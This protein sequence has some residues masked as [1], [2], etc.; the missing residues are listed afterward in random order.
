MNSEPTSPAETPKVETPV[1]PEGAVLAIDSS[2]ADALPTIEAPEP[3]QTPGAHM[4]PQKLMKMLKKMVDSEQLTP[5]QART[6]RKQFGIS[7]AYF[8]GKHITV[9]EKKKKKEIVTAS[10][11]A[12]RYN[13]STKGQKRSHGRGD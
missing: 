3:K 13:G 10:K 12:N 8:T 6:M 2:I 7:Q 5:E 9:E 11:R 4:T 1:V